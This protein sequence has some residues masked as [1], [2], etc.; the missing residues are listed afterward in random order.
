[1]RSEEALVF[2]PLQRRIQGANREISPGSLGEIPSD[3]QAVG[4]IRQADDGKEG[5]KFK[6]TEAAWWHN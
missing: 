5:R 3:C 6:C 4:V 2:E 1:M